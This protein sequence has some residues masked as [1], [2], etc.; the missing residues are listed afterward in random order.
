MIKLRIAMQRHGETS[1]QNITHFP[2]IQGT[3]KIP[4]ITV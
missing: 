4:E 2:G 1:Y 3:Q